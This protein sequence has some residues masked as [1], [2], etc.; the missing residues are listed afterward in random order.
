MHLGASWAENLGR[1]EREGDLVGNTQFAVLEWSY[2]HAPPLIIGGGIG[3]P[4]P[5]GGPKFGGGAPKCWGPKPKPP[6]GGPPVDSYDAV[7]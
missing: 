4:N 5:G 1:G 3:P 7:I 6:G 2:H